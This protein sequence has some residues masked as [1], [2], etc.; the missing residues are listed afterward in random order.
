MSIL[1]RLGTL[2]FGESPYTTPPGIPSPDQRRTLELYKFD[3]CPY[4][5]RVMR[6]IKKLGLSE[7]VTLRDVRRDGD[8]QAELI[9]LTNKTQ[10]PCLVI[11][12]TPLLESR[13][14]NRWLTAYDSRSRP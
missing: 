11:D 6:H 5:Q 10:V 4:C 14:I 1:S 13:D 7:Q 9:A 3:T 8:A 12:G 2:M